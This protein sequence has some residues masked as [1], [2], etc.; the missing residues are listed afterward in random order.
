M[1]N[2]TKG[3]NGVDFTANA[4]LIAPTTGGAGTRNFI[5]GPIA[6]HPGFEA[7]ALPVITNFNGGNPKVNV[8]RLNAAATVFVDSTLVHKPKV[9]V[10]NQGGKAD[11]HTKILSAAGLAN[12]THYQVI[13]NAASIAAGSCFTV[14][15]EPHSDP[16]TVQSATSLTNFL[17]SGGNFLGQCAA[18]RAYTNRGV[19]AGFAADGA[20]GGT[21]TFGNHNDPMAQFHGGLADQ[22]GSV[23]S[24]KL[25]SNPGKRIAYSSSDGSRYKAYVGRVTGVAT[26][27]GGWVHY[28]A[29]HNYDKSSGIVATNGK[30]ILLNAVLRPADRPDVCGLSIAS[31]LQVT[32]VVNNATP[33]VGQN[34]T[35]T[36]V[37]RNNGPVNATGVVVNDLLPSGPFASA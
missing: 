34:V 37:A 19:L 13:S 29:G 4:S 12:N 8:Y 15:T 30:R 17:R 24:F 23:T 32:K 18:V 11:I 6:I 28:L 31:D 14:A 33:N 35:F 3:K 7:Q 1:I 16:V 9:A 27:N 10:F 5:A 22:G 20:L 25:T 26:P 2:P 21:M 36:I